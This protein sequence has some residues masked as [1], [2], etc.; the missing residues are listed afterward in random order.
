MAMTFD[1]TLKDMG[2]ESPQGF[3]AAVDRPPTGPVQLLNVDL[4]T[5]TTTAPS[6]LRSV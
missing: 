2:R 5:V 4:S 6:E 1:A 3:L